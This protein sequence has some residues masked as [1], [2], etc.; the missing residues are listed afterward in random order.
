[1]AFDYS[2]SFAGIN[3]ALSNI[4]KQNEIAYQRQ[5]LAN[6]GQQIQSGD[7]GGAAQAA[8]SAGDAG[9]GLG[10]LKLGE[11]AKDRDAERQFFN[12]LGGGGA[13]QPSAAPVALG[14]PNEIETRFVN[15]V[16]GAGLTNPIGLGAVAAYGKAESGFSPQNVNRTWSDPSE[17]GQPGTAGGIMSWRSDRLANLQAF[18]RQRGEQQ[19]SV[20]TQALFLAQE[21]PQ[22]IP[23]LQA[24]K[25][26]Q[27]ANQIMANAWRFAG[28]D[29]PGGEN[30]RR[31]A[32]TQGYAQRFGGQAGPAPAVPVQI[33]ANEADVQR[34][35]AQQGNPV[36]DA[37]APVQVA[38]A[39]AQAGAP[40][41]DVP[42]PGAA[43]AQGFAI[44]GTDTVVP[45]SL[46][47]DPQVQ[48]FSRLMM[49][50]P[51]ERAR[52]AV[53]GQLDLAIKDAERRMEGGKPTDLQRNYEM[54]R[55]Q[56][57]QGSMLDYQKELRAQT[58][59]TV[60]QRGETEE[61]KAIGQAAGKRAGEMM[62]AAASGTKQLQRI[63]Q[64]ESLLKNVESGRL[65]PGR[66]SM[67]ALGKSLG[68][69]EDFLRGI[70][71]DPSKVGDAQAVN[72]ITG[73]MVVDM[74]GSGG[75]PANN[76]SDADRAFITGTV[77]SLA[78]DPRGNEIILEAGRRTAQIDIDKAKAWR[79]WRKD[80]KGGSFDD[81]E[82]Q[83]GEKLASQD[84]FADLA[85]KA[86][87]ILGPKAPAGGGWQDLGG[88]IKIRKKQ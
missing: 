86:E 63:G 11:T 69:N 13:A 43:E 47:N 57:Y 26:P 40:V 62:A 17:S 79:E 19:P 2:S 39:P 7:Y 74:I 71:L 12:I 35:E 83:W 53:K 77:A 1:M 50:A 34:L 51:T 37:P 41:S 68:V 52:A 20:E 36:V 32:L 8:F 49:V 72:A 25:T 54:A 64:L 58:N 87:A 45:Q 21:N 15:T 27:E 10:L 67:A 60:D 9:V 14:N 18:A 16:K 30:A 84:R 66:M 85:K 28:Y 33:A 24:A 3:N 44:P 82:V 73:R 59:V 46:M 56:G 4:G 48:R 31:L 80:N 75:F 5:R 78:N 70:G 23:A 22:L 81:F 42:A 29:R 6:L 55:R 61:A 65:Q 88:G 38:Q 76:F